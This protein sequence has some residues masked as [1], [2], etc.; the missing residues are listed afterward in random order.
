MYYCHVI[1]PKELSDSAN[2]HELPRHQTVI[3]FFAIMCTV[4]EKQTIQHLTLT[5][6]LI[7]DNYGER[8]RC[9]DHPLIIFPQAEIYLNIK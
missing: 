4:V 9:L 3:L 8:Q 7:D 5:K 2:C 1:L 6:Y